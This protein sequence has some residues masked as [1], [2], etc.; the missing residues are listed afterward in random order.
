MGRGDADDLIAL[1]R[2]IEA[3]QTIVKLLAVNADTSEDQDVFSELLSRVDIPIDLSKLISKS[4]DEEGLMLTHRLED[5]QVAELV[6]IASAIE[7]PEVIEDEINEDTL[8]S[9]QRKEPKK[10]KKMDMKIKSQ[11]LMKE[12]DREKAEAWVMK[13]E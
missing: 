1:A 2:T 9:T 11:R 6:S 3:T 7:H 8:L 12:A 13:Q 10:P 5:A 4:I